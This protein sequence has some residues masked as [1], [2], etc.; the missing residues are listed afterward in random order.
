MPEF[1]DPEQQHQNE[2]AAILA[3]K[4]QVR[5]GGWPKGKPRGKK[6]KETPAAGFD[7]LA[8]NG[9]A[10]SDDEYFEPVVAASNMEQYVWTQALILAMQTLQ[11][12]S[13]D[14]VQ[15]CVPIA[16]KA[17]DLFNERFA[18]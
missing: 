13:A 4:T 6:V 9:T 17:V 2:V 7:A 8:K 1:Y 5:K 15:T 12:R 16:D 10:V 14:R 18:A 3:E 11:V